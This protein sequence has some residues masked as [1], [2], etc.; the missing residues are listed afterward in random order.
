MILSL[1]QEYRR[2][3]PQLRLLRQ[4]GRKQARGNSG[5]WRNQ[6]WSFQQRNHCHSDN[7]A[8]VIRTTKTLSFQQQKHCH[9]DQRSKC[10]SNNKAIVI[11]TNK[12]IV[13]PTTKPLSFGPTKQ[14]SFQQRNHCHSN[15][16]A[17]IIRTNETI[18]HSNN[19]T[20]VIP[21]NETIVIPTTKPLSFRGAKPR[22]ICFS[23]PAKN[24]MSR[25]SAP[26]D[27]PRNLR[28]RLGIRVGRCRRLL[29]VL[30][31]FVNRILSFR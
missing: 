1:V 7:K 30:L 10:H 8:I 5:H 29:V 15:K 20:S 14:V 17:I 26:Q 12:T 22:G 16:E 18:C 19:E 23:R 13:I 6:P 25:T 27:P 31:I 3:R 2:S 21:T 24:R 9:S 11:R 28:L 4:G